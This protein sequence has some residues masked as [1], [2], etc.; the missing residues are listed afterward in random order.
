MQRSEVAAR[1][2]RDFQRRRGEA[3]MRPSRRLESTVYK[4]HRGGA[5]N[6][7]EDT[8]GGKKKKFNMLGK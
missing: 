5:S 3:G 6:P 4:F 1:W 2:V 8:R 7:Q